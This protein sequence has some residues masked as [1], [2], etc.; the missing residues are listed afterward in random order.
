MYIVNHIFLCAHQSM[1]QFAFVHI[2]F[3]TLLYLLFKEITKKT[4]DLLLHIF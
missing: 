1:I 2:Q 4:F 3:P